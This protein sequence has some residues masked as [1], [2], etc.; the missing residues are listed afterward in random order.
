MLMFFLAKYSSKNAF[1]VVGCWSPSTQLRPTFETILSNLQ[2]VAESTFTSVHNDSFQSMRDDWRLEIQAMFDD[3]KEKE[4]VCALLCFPLTNLVELH[5][6]ML[7]KKNSG[8]CKST[9]QSNLEAMITQISAVKSNSNKF[10]E[11]SYFAV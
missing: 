5:L 2:V 3:L 4:K 9:L 1:F 6:A 7:L 8:T 10:T 11:M